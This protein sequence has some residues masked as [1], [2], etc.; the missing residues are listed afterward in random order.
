MSYLSPFEC[1]DVHNFTSIIKKLVRKDGD[2]NLFAG[3]HGL[4]GYCPEYQ[5]VYD[6]FTTKPS[7]ALASLQDIMV[8]ALIDCGAWAL[9][10]VFYNYAVHTNAAGEALINWKLPGTFDATAFNAPTFT[11]LEG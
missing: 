6:A 2:G 11:A 5:A 7:A 10:D 3:V 4:G 9:L 8:R 1:L